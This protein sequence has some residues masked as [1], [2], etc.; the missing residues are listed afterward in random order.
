MNLRKN[1][2]TTVRR[3]PR[4]Q[5]AALRQQTQNDDIASSEPQLVKKGPKWGLRRGHPE[6]GVQPLL[7]VLAT[8][9]RLP[10][11]GT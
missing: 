1:L 3:P 5:N 8:V 9:L 7:S 6:Q 10:L 2:D 4:T 11:V